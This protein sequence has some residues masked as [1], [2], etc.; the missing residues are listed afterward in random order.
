MAA[1]VEPVIEDLGFNL[2]R[3]KVSGDERLH[4]ADHG[5]AAGRHHVGER[6]RHGQPGDLAG[7]RPR[8]SRSPQ[9]YHL[10][11]SSPGID[12][13]LVR[14]SDFER[15]TGYEAKI[16]MAVPLEGRKRFRGF[17]RGV[18]DGDAVIELPD[19][20]EGLEPIARLP[21]TDLGEAHLVLTDDLIRESC[22][23]APRR[24]TTMRTTTSDQ[25]RACAPTARPD[26]DNRRRSNFDGCQ[27]QQA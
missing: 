15:W 16:E 6:L 13:P 8:G 1:I 11:I 5:R 22:G 4:R 3:V 20:K 24:R 7:A 25:R 10:E 14:A 18:E 26:D 17:I 19:V 27:R 12:R 23:A 9:A 2:V 21:L